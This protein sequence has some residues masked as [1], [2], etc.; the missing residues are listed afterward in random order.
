M[1]ST[2]SIDRALEKLDVEEEFLGN[3]LTIG[4][5]SSPLG[6]PPPPPTHFH[7]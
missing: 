2:T 5:V 3:Y 7:S 4:R 6:C 1:L